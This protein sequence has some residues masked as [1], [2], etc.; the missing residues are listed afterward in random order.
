MLTFSLIKFEDELFSVNSLNLGNSFNSV[1]FGI[2]FKTSDLN[3]S[4]FKISSF[5]LNFLNIKLKI[6]QSSKVSPIG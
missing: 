2:K 4:K 6:F 3:E 1:K 5:F